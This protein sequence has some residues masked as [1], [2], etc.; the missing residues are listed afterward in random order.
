ME[1]GTRSRKGLA[2]FLKC[3]VISEPQGRRA[4]KIV[5]FWASPERPQAYHFGTIWV[6]TMWWTNIVARTYS[7]ETNVVVSKYRGEKTS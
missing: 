3:S 1:D 7:G 2:D 6:Q 4:Q 5:N